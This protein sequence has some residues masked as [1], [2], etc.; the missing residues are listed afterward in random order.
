MEDLIQELYLRVWNKRKDYRAKAQELTYL[1]AIARFILLEHRTKQRNRKATLSQIE[2]QDGECYTNLD[3]HEEIPLLRS[4]I[5][6]LP[7]MQRRVIQLK[8]LEGLSTQEVAKLLSCLET[9]VRSHCCLGLE[10]LREKLE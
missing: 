6:D 3:H 5:D 2:R 7:T 8:Y 10:K 9:T 4:L 1:I